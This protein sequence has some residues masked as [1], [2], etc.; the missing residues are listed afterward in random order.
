MPKKSPSKQSSPSKKLMSLKAMI[1]KKVNK[2][3]GFLDL[4]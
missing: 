1:I 4:V 2:K 3:V